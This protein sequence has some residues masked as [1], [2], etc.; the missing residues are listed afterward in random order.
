MANWELRSGGMGDGEFIKTPQF[1]PSKGWAPRIIIFDKNGMH[2]Q[3]LP[4]KKKSQ[5][6]ELGVQ[7]KQDY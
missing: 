6:K 7:P 2:I 4:M 3:T 1:K 5:E